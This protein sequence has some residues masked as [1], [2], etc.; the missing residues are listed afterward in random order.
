M[1]RSPL[2]PLRRHLLARG[3]DALS[4]LDLLAMVLGSATLARSLPD[5]SS[6][7]P[8]L[9]QADL[10]SLPRF[11]RGRAARVLALVE[12]S[13]RITCRPLVRGEA[14][15]CGEQV[16]AAYGPRLATR[17]QEVFVALAL[18]AKHRVIAERELFRGTLT[19]VEVHPR[20]LFRSLIRD[21]AA[22]ALLLHNHPS[23]DPEPSDED[24]ALS[25]RLVSAGQLLGITVLDFLI[26]AGGRFVS[27]VD[28]GLMPEVRP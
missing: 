5:A 2:G 16:V 10:L 20:E 27:F 8:D 7:W 19:S 3:P 12:L 22:A 28:R 18:D 9:G 25:R 17:R 15:R 6:R 23:G 24:R 4:D 14:I 1:T 11:G 21:G 26:V 13:R